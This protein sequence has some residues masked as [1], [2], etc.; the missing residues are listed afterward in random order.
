MGATLL[1]QEATSKFRA[2]LS[3]L[4]FGDS[5]MVDHRGKR[6]NEKQE[7]YENEQGD[8]NNNEA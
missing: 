3:L 5:Q 2:R 8:C 1:D 6:D 4:Q 7:G